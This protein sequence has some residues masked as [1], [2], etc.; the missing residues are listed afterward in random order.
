MPYDQLPITPIEFKAFVWVLGT[1]LGIISFI[2]IIFV[3]SFMKMAKDVNDIKT[4]V[5]VQASK[6]DDLERRVH[7]LEGNVA[8]Q[9]KKHG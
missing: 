4:T 2:G 8:L 6:H 3:N 7:S 9:K 5:M 1:S